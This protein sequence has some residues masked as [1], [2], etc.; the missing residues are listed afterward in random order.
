MITVRGNHIIVRRQRAERTGG[1]SF[2]TVI[3]MAESAD[4]AHPVLRARDA[5][6]KITVHSGED[7]PA[8]AVVDTIRAVKPDRIGHGTHIIEDPAAIDLVLESGVTL[9]M[10]PWSNYLTNSV[11]R[12]ED[13]P[14][15]KLFELGVKV[16]INSDDPEVLETNLNNE[17]RIA[18]EILGMSMDDIAQ[19][20][21]YALDA[22]FV[23]KAQKAKL[24][25]KYWM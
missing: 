7:T 14:L 13:H 18:H 17:Y 12:I 5:G 2:L 1:N 9:E 8:S 3:Q 25:S 20:N 21:R 23:S 4:F 19:C 22:A 24:R 16:T 15:K 10:N 11:T 6:L